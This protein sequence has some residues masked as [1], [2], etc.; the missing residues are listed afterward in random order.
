MIAAYPKHGTM[1]CR[2]SVWSVR[3]HTLTSRIPLYQ[4]GDPETGC[5][6]GSGLSRKGW[7]GEKREKSSHYVKIMTL[8]FFPLPFTSVT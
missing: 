8:L 1:V 6:T 7:Q 4:D 5:Q 2:A 3:T